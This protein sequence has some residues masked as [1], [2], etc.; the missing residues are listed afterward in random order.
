MAPSE[1]QP[2]DATILAMGWVLFKDSIGI[3]ITAMVHTQQLQCVMAKFH[4]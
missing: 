2:L 4:V 1:L 3:F